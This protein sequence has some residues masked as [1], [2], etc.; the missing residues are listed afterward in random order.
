ML[1]CDNLNANPRCGVKITTCFAKRS[2]LR[3]RGVNI[4]IEKSP[5]IEIYLSESLKEL[6]Q[7]YG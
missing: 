6:Y 5:P 3:F 7:A 4:K 1:N 2:T